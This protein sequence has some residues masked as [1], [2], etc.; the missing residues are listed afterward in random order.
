M[1]W[2]AVNYITVARNLLAGDG[3][4]DWVGPLVYWPPLYPAMRAGGGLFGLDPY[5][6]AGPLNAVLFGL[7]VLVAGWVAAAPSAVPVPVALGL[8]LDRAGPSARRS[9]VRA[10]ERV[11]FHFAV[12]LAVVPLLLAARVAPREK[13]KRI[14]VYTLIAAVPVG[15]WM[16]RNFLLVGSTTGE[17]NSG[18]YSFPFIVDEVFAIALGDWWLVGLTAPVLLALAMAACHA[19]CRR[20]DSKRD[21]PVVSDVAWGPL[22]VFGGFSLAYLTLFVVAMMSGGTWDG[23]QWRFLAP[24]YVPL[25][26]ASL[27]LMDGALRCVRQRA[28]RGT[29]AVGER[30]RCRW[31]DGPPRSTA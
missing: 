16:L 15:L 1:E 31:L 20:S 13:M 19:F 12:I 7:T 17:R 25:L 29:V 10:S 6:V 24:V 9:G 23:L 11:G 22:R 8:P 3:F 14:A 2:D 27:V 18:F 28:S 21:T 4:V 30:R 5:A 26:F